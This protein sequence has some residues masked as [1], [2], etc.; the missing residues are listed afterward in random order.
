ML[1]GSK[2]PS[3]SNARVKREVQGTFSWAKI[4][5]RKCLLHQGKSNAA[6]WFSKASG[7]MPPKWVFRRVWL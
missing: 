7:L 4:I 6:T 5:G 1:N 2:G 3:C